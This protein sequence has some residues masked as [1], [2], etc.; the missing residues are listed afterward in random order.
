MKPFWVS[1]IYLNEG[2]K[3][4]DIRPLPS[5]YCSFDCVFCPFGRTKVKTDS[6]DIIKG[7]DNFIKEL[8]YNL[9][10]NKIDIVFINPNGEA[11]ANSELK[12]I[13]TTIKKHNIE[14]ELLTNGYILNNIEYRDT[15]NLCDKVIGELAVTTEENFKKIQRPLEGYTLK[16]YIDNMTEFNKWFKGKFTIAITILKGYS[17]NEDDIE[18]FKNAIKRIQPDDIT[19]ETPTREKFKNAFGIYEEKLKYIEQRLKNK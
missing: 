19:L 12:N 9:Q 14:I 4:I 2:K 11:L 15:L 10:K 8:E 17:D 1:K 16:K 7:T 3:T 6:A 13:I 5:K 18:F